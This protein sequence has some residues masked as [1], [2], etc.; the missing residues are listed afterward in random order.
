MNR[1]III[2]IQPGYSL[3]IWEGKLNYFKITDK[4]AINEVWLKLVEYCRNQTPTINDLG[5]IEYTAIIP[6]SLLIR[7]QFFK[8]V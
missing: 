8:N 5:T 1:K 7:L 6:E 4:S 3:L 2:S